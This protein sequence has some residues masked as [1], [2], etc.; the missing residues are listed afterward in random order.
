[1]PYFILNRYIYLFLEAAQCN[2]MSLV[3]LISE[4][5]SFLCLDLTENRDS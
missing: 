2:L 3:L 1:M 4:Q 5:L